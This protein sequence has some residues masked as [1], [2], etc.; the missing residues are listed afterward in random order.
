M[1]FEDQSQPVILS[2]LSC[3]FCSQKEVFLEN[4]AEQAT[5]TPY[6]S[7]CNCGA[8][9][10]TYVVEEGVEHLVEPQIYRFERKK[11]EV[12]KVEGFKT[13]EREY[14]AFFWQPFLLKNRV[15]VRAVLTWR[16]GMLGLMS[17]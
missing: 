3:P 12:R 13:K 9:L 1:W 14:V 17:K 16:R 11:V 10:M 4:E 7:P 15:W 6:V 2:Q 8:L 5:R